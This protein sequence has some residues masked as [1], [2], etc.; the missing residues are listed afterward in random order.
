MKVIQ[1]WNDQVKRTLRRYTYRELFQEN[2]LLQ[3][4][5]QKPQSAIKLNVYD[6]LTC[7]DKVKKIQFKKENLTLPF[8]DPQITRYYFGNHKVIDNIFFFGL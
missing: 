4:S 6:S 3:C 1:S 8:N 7:I 5:F 2:Y